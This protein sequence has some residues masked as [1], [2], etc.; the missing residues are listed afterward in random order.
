MSYIYQRDKMA[1]LPADQGDGGCSTSPQRESTKASNRDLSQPNGDRDSTFAPASSD[2]V[3][4]SFALSDMQNFANS[5]AN[6]SSSAQRAAGPLIA[7]AHGAIIFPFSEEQALDSVNNPAGKSRKRGKLAVDGCPTDSKHSVAEHDELAQGSGEVEEM[8]VDAEPNDMREDQSEDEAEEETDEEKEVKKVEARVNDNLPYR[9]IKTINIPKRSYQDRGTNVEKRPQEDDP[10][11]WYGTMP[12]RESL[13]TYVCDEMGL[14]YQ[15]TANEATVLQC[16]P[17][18]KVSSE[19]IRKCH[20][21]SLDEQYNQY[22]LK[23]ETEIPRPTAAEARRGLPRAP[24][25]S[26]GTAAKNSSQTG[27]NKAAQGFARPSFK[28]SEP[29]F[30]REA[31]SRQLEMT[32]IVVWRDLYKCSFDQIRGFCK[33]DFDWVISSD[34]VEHFYYL[35]RPSAYGS[36][37]GRIAEDSTKQKD[38]EID[39]SVEAAAAAAGIL[40]GSFR[41]NDGGEQQ[42]E[43]QQAATDPQTYNNVSGSW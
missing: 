8:E 9:S 5:T 43:K 22:G 37:G 42:I 41:S 40:A 23:N 12:Y 3:L 26:S 18:G 21:L 29:R 13:I 25:V 2:A 20:L 34:Q 38:V 16:F 32:Q 36:T 24:R 28:N 17:E 1:I 19:W 11:T 4:K 10:T 7:G 15:R 33:D 30:V 27:R 31:P 39:E 35:V 6:A 14:S